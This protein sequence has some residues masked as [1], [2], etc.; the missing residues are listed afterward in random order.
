[1]LSWQPNKIITG[2]KTH[3]LGRQPSND[4]NCQI[5]FTLLQWL[6]RKCNLTIFLCKSMGV[7]CCLGNQTKRQIGRLLA[8]F[9]CPYP[10]NICTKLESYY[11]SGFGDVVIKKNPFCLNLML[12]WKPNKIAT[13]Q[14]T[15]WVD[16]HPMIINANYG[17]HHF[18]GYGENAI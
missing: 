14:C 8:I 18:T 15:N 3:K 16:N 13:G 4:H 2:H 5:W 12:P 11:F 9:S 6:W 10:F 17:S 7:F 1:M